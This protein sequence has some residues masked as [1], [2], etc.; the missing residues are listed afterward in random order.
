LY[1]SPASSDSKQLVA[2]PLRLP[3][4]LGSA[5]A[6]Q[7]GVA[8]DEAARAIELRYRAVGAT[9]A[10]VASARAARAGTTIAW[11]AASQLNPS[12]LGRR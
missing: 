10:S 11:R 2:C 9:I 12:P 3:N 5:A 8:A 4:G 7:L 1:R 6:A